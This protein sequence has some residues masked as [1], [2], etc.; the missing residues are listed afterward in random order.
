MK[1]ESR[2]IRNRMI[3]CIKNYSYVGRNHPRCPSIK[4]MVNYIKDVHKDW[5]VDI[6]DWSC[7]KTTSCAGM[8]YSTGG[9]TRD[10]DGVRLI[11]RKDGSNFIHHNTT[12]TYRNNRE[13]AEK[14]LYAEGWNKYD[15]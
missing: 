8:R 14:I 11:V 7:S 15:E 13:V 12:E 5:E 10:Y 6:T 2:K 9:G 3:D 1:T 4:V